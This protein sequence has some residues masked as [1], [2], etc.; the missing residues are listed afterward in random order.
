M[1]CCLCLQASGSKSRLGHLWLG[2]A[3]DHCWAVFVAYVEAA[4]P[5]DELACNLFKNGKL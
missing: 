1:T 5:G 2:Y 4:A 3:H